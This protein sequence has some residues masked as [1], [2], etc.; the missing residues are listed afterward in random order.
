MVAAD[1][2]RRDRLA[3]VIRSVGCLASDND[4]STLSLAEALNRRF[5][6]VVVDLPLPE[7]SA[8]GL[9]GVARREGSAWRHAGIVIVASPAL[10]SGEAGLLSVGASGLVPHDAV[11]GQLRALLEVLLGVKPRVRVGTSAVLAIATAK[12]PLR[13]VGTVVDAS[14]S[15]LLVVANAVPDIGT[16][17]DFRFYLPGQR[18]PITGRGAVCRRAQS[19]GKPGF[20]IRV[21]AIDPRSLDHLRRFIQVCGTS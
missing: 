20:V 16:R 13:L 11:V 4:A 14:E 12:G 5:D 19:D 9:L 1:P 10:S 17:V 7:V 18:T 8:R 3:A 6:L 15:G 21:E 2:A